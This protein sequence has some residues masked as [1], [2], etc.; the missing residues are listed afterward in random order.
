MPGAKIIPFPSRRRRGPPR[1]PTEIAEWTLTLDDAGVVILAVDFLGRAM[2]HRSTVD[3]GEPVVSRVDL[4][5][6]TELLRE[7]R[8]RR[9]RFARQGVRSIDGS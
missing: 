8:R 4:D 2:L 1:A 3:G 6:L 7:A 9:R 5:D